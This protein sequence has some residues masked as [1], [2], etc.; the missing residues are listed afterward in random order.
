MWEWLCPHSGLDYFLTFLPMFVA[1]ICGWFILRFS[2]VSGSLH[3]VFFVLAGMFAALAFMPVLVVPAYGVLGFFYVY[4]PVL[5]R[6]A[7]FAWLRVVLPKDSIKL[8]LMMMLFTW[9]NI[10]ILGGSLLAGRLLC[11]PVKRSSLIFILFV[12]STLLVTLS[13]AWVISFVWR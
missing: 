1:V 10:G 11:L 5:T 7:T 12:Y 4:V 2:G 6:H 9:F 3:L 13:V 8:V